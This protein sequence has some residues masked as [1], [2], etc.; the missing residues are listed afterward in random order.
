MT[1]ES[2]VC[3]LI[4]G[5]HVM[6][7][8]LDVAT[9]VCS[10]NFVASVKKCQLPT[11]HMSSMLHAVKILENHIIAVGATFMMLLYT[12]PSGDP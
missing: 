8:R 10:T 11:M 12:A 2:K 1:L 5:Y 7:Q 4:V 3:L 9:Q 6:H